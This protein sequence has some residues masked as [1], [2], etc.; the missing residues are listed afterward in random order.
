MESRLL[1]SSNENE[2][3]RVC[4]ELQAFV[5]HEQYRLSKAQDLISIWHL[6]DNI[7]NSY[8]KQIINLFHELANLNRLYSIIY[9]M[10]EY[11]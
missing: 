7:E 6:N 2:F 3:N 11:R 4:N 1:N 10:I 5:H 8:E 9:I